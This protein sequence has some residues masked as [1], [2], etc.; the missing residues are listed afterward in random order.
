MQLFFWKPAA[1]GGLVTT[2]DNITIATATS[3]SEQQLKLHK[4]TTRTCVTPSNADAFVLDLSIQ[5]IR[6]EE[7]QDCGVHTPA[8]NTLPP[9]PYTWANWVGNQQSSPTGVFH[10]ST[11]DE[12]KS[13]V[14][15]ARQS[16]KRI[17]CVASAFS[18]SSISKTNDY[19]VNTKSLSRIYKPTFDQE[20]NLWTVPVQS[21]VSIKALDDYL[22][23]HDPPLAMSGNVFLESVLYGGIIA[24]GAHGAE[25][26]GRCLSDQVTEISI[27]DGTGTLQTFNADK[28]P[29]EFS[30]ACVN[31]GLFGIIYT[32]TLKVIPM[33]DSRYRALDYNM[34]YNELFDP[35]RKEC[36][37]R[38]KKL[39]QENA[40]MELFYFP[41]NH[42]GRCRCN[43]HVRIKTLNPTPQ[44]PTTDSWFQE[45][46]RWL[47]NQ[48]FS[49]RIFKAIFVNLLP[50]RLSWTPLVTRLMHRFTP[51]LDCV[52]EIPDAVHFLKNNEI[53]PSWLVEFS[54]KCD[55]GDDYANVIR[56]WDHVAQ[57]VY[58]A[59]NERNEYPL[60]VAMEA[61]FNKASRCIMSPIYDED[62]EAIFF[63]IELV[64]GKNTPGF[65]EFSEKI[66]KVWMEQ[67]N[68]LPHWAKVWENFEGAMTLVRSQMGSRLDTF[69][70][71]R[72]QYDPEGLFL[73]PMYER[74]FKEA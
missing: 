5:D 2:T 31:L 64:S 70:Q 15:Q 34:P 46:H 23:N 13:I 41:F 58:E 59:A 33:S 14:L 21:G 50:H 18:M 67:Y 49:W 10:P 11:L 63:S 57:M 51:L 72:R 53:F 25:I 43:D 1:V 39:V 29:I 52:L 36:G 55:D 26:N 7:Q 54:I 30:A 24:I 48:Q 3:K 6:K 56:A 37:Q 8:S 22:R 42:T 19:L 66:A 28:D 32:L 61:R 71:V 65:M 69:N 38:L 68:G 16:H 27:V 73:M 44:L 40:S 17:R 4:G 60:N 45:M 20:H 9:T 47:A 74:L 35:L 12:L 62:P